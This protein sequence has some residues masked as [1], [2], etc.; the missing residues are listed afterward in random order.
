MAVLKRINK[1]IVTNLL[2]TS[3]PT[4]IAFLLSDV[5]TI[6]DTILIGAIKN[7]SIY[8]ASLSAINISARVLLFISAISRGINVSSSTIL[9]RYLA[10]NDKEKIQST[11]IHTIIL[12]VFVISLPL[13][14]ICLIFAKPIILFIGND[15][16]IYEVGKGYYIAIIIGFSFSSILST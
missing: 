15:P 16:M 3:I 7:E 12:N 14:I 10:T 6:V 4:I 5:F 1:T 2:N 8:A 13:V 9:S 11:L